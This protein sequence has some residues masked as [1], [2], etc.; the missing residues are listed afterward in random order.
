MWNGMRNIVI[1]FRS[2]DV[3]HNRFICSNGFYTNSYWY[4]VQKY[5]KLTST[6]TSRVGA[7]YWSGHRINHPFKIKLTHECLPIIYGLF[8]GPC[9]SWTLFRINE[10]WWWPN[11][12]KQYETRT[13]SNVLKQ[14]KSGSERAKREET[15]TLEPNH[16]GQPI[17]SSICQNIDNS[18][19]VSYVFMIHCWI[20]CV[21]NSFILLVSLKTSTIFDYTF[22]EKWLKIG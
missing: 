1:W 3:V 2:Y 19:I 20:L 12:Q 14:Y 17:K 13:I 9:K 21:L 8:I 18:I 22:I 15:E 6:H 11:A 7:W 16:I 4:Y 5:R 10:W